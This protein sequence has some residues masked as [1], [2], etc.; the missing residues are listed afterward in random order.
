MWAEAAVFVESGAEAGAKGDD[1]FEAFTTD[2]G[3]ALDIGV[4]G[5]AGG[6]AEFFLQGGGEGEAVPVFISKVRRAADDALADHAW[7]SGADASVF[8]EVFDEFCE[9]LDNGLGRCAGGGVDADAVGDH[10]AIWVEHG[11]FESG[12]ADV[13]SEGVRG[14]GVVLH[15]FS[16]AGEMR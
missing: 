9:E 5:D 2:D 6:L 14:G 16:V 15:D 4:V 7:E 8:W 1:H 13:D 12:A 10:F 3:E 11:G